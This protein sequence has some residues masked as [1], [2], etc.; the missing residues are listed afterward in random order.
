MSAQRRALDH[1]RDLS[2]NL[3]AYLDP[4]VPGTRVP[5]AWHHGSG[6]HVPGAR[7]HGYWFSDQ[8]SPNGRMTDEKDHAERG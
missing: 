3:T 8:F 7:H 1:N 5:G 2:S 4:V 6:T